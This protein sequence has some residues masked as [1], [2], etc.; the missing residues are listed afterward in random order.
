MRRIVAPVLFLL[1]LTAYGYAKPTAYSTPTAKSVPHYDLSVKVIPDAHRLEVTGTLVIPPVGEARPSFQVGLSDVMHDLKVEVLEPKSCAGPAKIEKDR[2]INKLVVWKV[3]A[4][5]VIPAGEAIHLRFSYTGGEEI[6]FVFY[7][8]AEGSFAGG[9]NTAWYPQ[10]E[11]E[12]KGRIARG[13]GKMSFSV[14]AEY[15]VIAT[16]RRVSAPDKERDGSFLFEVTQPSMLSFAAAK[17]VV[18]ERV[19]GGTRTAAYLL[20][21]R[22]HAKDYLDKCAVVIEVLTREFG[23]SPYG[24]FALVEVPTQQAGK[25][26]FAGASFE[27][28]IMSNG[29]FLDRQ[30]NTAYYGHEI[31]HQWWGVSVGKKSG[32]RGVLMLDEALAQ[33]GSLRAVEIIEGGRAA[34]RY[35]RTGY[36]GY[37]ALQNAQG[38]FMVEAAGFDQPLSSLMQGE[39]RRILADGKGFI[40]YDMLSREVGREKF[41]RILQG[42]ARQYAGNHIGWDE[43]LQAIEKGAGRDLKWFYEQWFD[44]RGAPEWDINWRQ[45][46]GSVR[47]AIIQSPPFYRATVEVL[48]EGDEYQTS[49]Q[50]VELRG[51]RTEFSFPLKFHARSLAVDPHFLVLHRT[52]QWRALK[53]AFAAH[54][55]ARGE[56]DKKRYDEAEKILREALEK[57]A[58]PDLHGGRFTLEVAMGQLFLDQKKYAEAKAYFQSALL[59]P[60]RRAE[61]LPWAY[62]YLA[63]AAKGLNDEAL[64]K[65]AVSGAVA[66]EL[67]LGGDT[68]AATEARSLLPK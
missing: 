58:E 45:E 29:E 68:G 28:F 50:T 53:P 1:A 26:D 47:G 13:I 25:A 27:G 56:R 61:V 18:E 65:Y 51:E 23:P 67:A 19:T 62:L 4:A 3:T 40:V 59:R 8:G 17:Y 5:N 60:V 12:T 57:E 14:P 48:I 16:G 24:D 22:S 52:T 41:N 64:L 10:V 66:A 38:Y 31:S 11:G 35:R 9:F 55:R 15:K 42:I 43:F 32:P 34:E 54:I 63:Q 30:F 49:L 46:G 39:F 6:R 21:P 36:P 2:E 44:R 33:Y 7:V 37:I 20:K